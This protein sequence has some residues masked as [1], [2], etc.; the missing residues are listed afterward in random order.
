MPFIRFST[1]KRRTLLIFSISF[2]KEIISPY[3][4]YA[5]KGL[6]YIIIIFLL[7]H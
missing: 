2:N 3:A 6:I 4:Y 1:S 7:G 5:K